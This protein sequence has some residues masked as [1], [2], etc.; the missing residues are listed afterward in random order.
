MPI[1][2]VEAPWGGTNT[3]TLCPDHD[4]APA[5]GEKLVQ[6]P[7]LGCEKCLASALQKIEHLRSTV[8]TSFNAWDTRILPLLR[9]LRKRLEN[10][11]DE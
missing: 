5:V 4:S 7:V 1:E 8:V 2:D 11:K 10:A 6:T 9:D 3:R